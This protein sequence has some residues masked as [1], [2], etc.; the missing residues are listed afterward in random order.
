[1]ISA[2]CLTGFHAAYL[3][4]NIFRSDLK[5]HL[6][7]KRMHKSTTFCFLVAFCSILD[8]QLLRFFPWRQGNQ[9]NY[10]RFSNGYPNAEMTMRTLFSSALNGVIQLIVSVFKG[11]SLSSS[12][13]FATTLIGLMLTL[14]SIVMR[15]TAD[16]INKNDVDNTHDV[17]KV[18]ELEEEIRLLKERLSSI[19][20]TSLQ[21][22][23]HTSNEQNNEWWRLS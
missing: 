19:E 11:Y 1:M 8:A 16:S 14:S 20:L 7:A 5:H 2:R 15:K 4:V 22:T 18:H 23:Q 12:V 10:V 13:S 17:E 9:S 21:G 3:I 6:V